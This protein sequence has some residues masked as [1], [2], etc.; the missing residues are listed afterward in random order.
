MS[1]K[2]RAQ[3]PVVGDTIIL[4]TFSRNSNNFSDVFAIDSVDIIQEH[5]EE[6][7]C[8]NPVGT[9]LVES[10]PSGSIVR[11]DLGMYH[12]ELAT[13]GP[14]Y[15]VGRYHD[16]WNIRFRSGDDVAQYPQDFR[17][18]PDLWVVS[19]TPVVYSFDFHFTPNRMRRGSRKWLIIQI[20]PNVPRATDL[21]RFYENIAIS[22][23]L[24]INIE[25]NCGP[26]PPA[27][28]DLRLIIDNDPV[29]VRDK[30]FAYYQIDTADWECGIYDVWFEMD[31]AG[32]LEIS[33]KYN[34]QIF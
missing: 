33:P 11:D 17:I 5:P 13:S 25:L 3:N 4:R 20:V 7:T 16:V 8:A 22:A 24:R 32:N 30:V 27:E 29:T 19:P 2:D 1:K 12:I 21:Q 9:L 18:Y 15:T 10:I 31:F 14:T 26:C 6:Q 23:D 28:Q 34:I